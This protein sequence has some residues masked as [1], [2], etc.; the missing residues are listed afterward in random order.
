MRGQQAL[1]HRHG[2]QRVGS[3]VVRQDQDEVGAMGR[4]RYGRRGRKGVV[5]VNRAGFIGQGDRRDEGEEADRKDDE[6]WSD[7]R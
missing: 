6:A 3:L 2:P 4:V 7:R 5:V 1:E